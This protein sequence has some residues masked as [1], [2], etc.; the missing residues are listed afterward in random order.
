MESG[1]ELTKRFVQEIDHLVSQGII[2][3]RSAVAEKIGWDKTAISNVVNRRRDIPLDK[4]IRFKK[5]FDPGAEEG[6]IEYRDKYITAL[7]QR[8]QEQSTMIEY[9]KGIIDTLRKG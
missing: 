8:V 3:N 1:K 2:K 9:L 7:E 5:V 4:Y 6:G